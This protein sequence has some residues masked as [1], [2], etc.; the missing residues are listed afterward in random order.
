MTSFER[1]ENRIPMLLEEL[2]VPS[3]PDYTDDLFARTAATRQRPGRSFPERWPVM[4][5]LSRRFAVVPSIQWRYGALVALLAVAA[6]IAALVAGALISRVS[7][8]GPG[9]NGEILMVDASGN[10]VAADPVTNATRVVVP[11]SASPNYR[12]IVS[13]DGRRFLILR[14]AAAGSQNIFTVDLQGHETQITPD[15]LSAWHYIGWSPQSD[16]ILVRDNGGRVLLLD[17]TRSAEP[18]SISSGLNLGELWIGS[19]SNNTPNDAFRPA[20]GDEVMVVVDGHVIATLRIDGSSARTILDVQAMG[21]GVGLGA[22]Q[23]S[24][25]GRQIVFGLQAEQDGPWATYVMNADGTNLHPVSTVGDQLGAKWSPD[26][27]HIAFEYA[28]PPVTGEDWISHPIGIV[29]VETGQLRDVGPVSAKG[30]VSWAW[31]PDGTSI[32]EVPL[33]DFGKV[34]VVNATT[35]HTTTTPWTVDE[36]VSWQRLAP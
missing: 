3:L 1:F 35:G 18:R 7:P 31:S 4:S 20:T 2:A 14:A 28:T 19:G 8:F 11:S 24:P 29:D 10:V 30:Y 17:A 34:L 12:P 23:W 32:I 13:P 5:T 21:L 16:R 33:Q 15:P 36:P 6:V 9:R 22:P 27:K 25:D 26:G